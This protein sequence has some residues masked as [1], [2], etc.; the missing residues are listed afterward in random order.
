MGFYT[1]LSLNAR[2]KERK[3]W[4]VKIYSAP[5]NQSARPSFKMENLCSFSNKT[6]N[7]QI[8]C[9]MIKMIKQPRLP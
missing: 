4:S 2:I 8:I 9:F 6:M 5:D 1:I 7:N 3:L